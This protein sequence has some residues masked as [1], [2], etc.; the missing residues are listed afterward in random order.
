M[1]NVS[2]R[3][4]KTLEN[5][6]GVLKEYHHLAP[7]GKMLLII[8]FHFSIGRMFCLTSQSECVFAPKDKKHTN[9]S[10]FNFKASQGALPQHD[11]SN[12]MIRASGFVRGAL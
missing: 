5:P 1:V 10:F 3:H 9:L 8:C 12:M 11:F 2:Q 7:S 6:E 4:F